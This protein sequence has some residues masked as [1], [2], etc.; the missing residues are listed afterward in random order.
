M[1]TLPWSSQIDLHR[2]YA[3]QP[4]LLYITDHTVPLFRA[5][6]DVDFR[7]YAMAAEAILAFFLADRPSDQGSL[8]A[9]LSR[10]IAEQKS[11]TVRTADRARFA[12]FQQR[13]SRIV[14]S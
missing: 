1:R 5:L 7:R 3:S 12:E 2:H 6:G 13:E 9:A 8:V 10:V 11:A 4:L 14:R